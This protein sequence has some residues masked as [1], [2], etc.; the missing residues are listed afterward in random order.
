MMHV[1]STEW[2]ALFK[3]WCPKAKHTGDRV[4][5]NDILLCVVD[6]PELL[7]YLE[8]ILFVCQKYRLSLK[9]SKCDFLKER[10]EH[11][12]HD[13]TSEGNFPLQSKFNMITD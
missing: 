7:N 11:V 3:S 2:N 13:L 9:L 12:G 1:L 8:C 6:L 10:V 5:I 4:I